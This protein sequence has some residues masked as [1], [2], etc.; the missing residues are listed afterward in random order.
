MRS[1]R[2]CYHQQYLRTIRPKVGNVCMRAR[3]E[4]PVQAFC[5][6]LFTTTFN[7]EGLRPLQ[8]PRADMGLSAV[9]PALFQNNPGRLKTT[10][11]TC[12][13]SVPRYG[14]GGRTSGAQVLN[15]RFTGSHA[16]MC[17]HMCV[18]KRTHRECTYIHTYACADIHVHRRIYI[19]MSYCQSTALGS[20]IRKMHHNIPPVSS[21]VS[22]LS[23]TPGPS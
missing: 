23:M 15:G 3:A 5:R 10:W 20:L 22:I 18:C 7:C 19:H 8:G 21:P 14:P 2:I 11:G 1:C 4:A 17:L 16:R 9:T 6:L 13:V 12:A